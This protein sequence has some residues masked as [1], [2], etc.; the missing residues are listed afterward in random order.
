[1]PAAVSA[2]LVPFDSAQHLL[3]DHVSWS[4]YEHVLREFEERAGFRVAF[5]E[6]RLEIMSPLPKHEALASLI[7][8]LLGVMCLERDIEMIGLGSTTFR[9]EV[10]GKGLEPDECYYIGENA[11]ID[12]QLDDRYDAAVHPPPDL[13][14]EVDITSRSL[15]REPIYAA[16][17]VPEL[18]R[19]RV[20]LIQCRQLGDGGRYA[21][22][23]VSAAFPFLKP[24]DLWPWVLRLRDESSVKVLR[25][26]QVWA[27]QL[28]G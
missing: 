20:G 6:G 15:P 26:F 4:F 14:I 12:Q 8:R 27:R 7:D 3:L 28:P 11:H 16:L 22:H 17:G 5:D 9:D 10:K 18:W 24:N 19:V 1:M 25:E 23:E 2:K 21:D 13:A